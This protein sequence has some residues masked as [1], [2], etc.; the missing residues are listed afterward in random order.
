MAA[1]LP[2]VT[3][4]ATHRLLLKPGWTPWRSFADEAMRRRSSPPGR[5]PSVRRDASHS[6][7]PRGT[8]WHRAPSLADSAW[9][10]TERIF[11]LVERAG[12]LSLAGQ[13][14]HVPAAP[15][16]LD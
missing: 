13:A 7:A 16:S 10:S 14:H 8:T 9:C 5:G 15:L 6:T 3:A 11:P 2:S 12:T 4:P 1:W